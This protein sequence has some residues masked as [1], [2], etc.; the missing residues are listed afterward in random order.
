MEQQRYYPTGLGAP[1]P[2]LSYKVASTLLRRPARIDPVI[3]RADRSR[4]KEI[5]MILYDAASLHPTEE[6]RKE[7]L[8][9]MSALIR[10]FDEQRQNCLLATV[11][12]EPAGLIHFETVPPWEKRVCE[13]MRLFVRPAWRSYGLARKLVFETIASAKAAGFQRV[14][15]NVFEA[16]HEMVIL[17]RILGFKEADQADNCNYLAYS[18]A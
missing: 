18:L 3:Q 9:K 5:E 11:E 8:E 15:V 13:I 12:G 4:V 1:V 14:R 6:G 17:Y 7:T 10:E 16:S 2:A